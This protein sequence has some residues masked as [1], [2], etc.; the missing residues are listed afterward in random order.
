MDYFNP[1]RNASDRVYGFESH[2]GIF[3]ARSDDGGLSWNHPTTVVSHL[4]DGQ[5][6]VNFEILPEIAVD[7][8][9]S[10]PNGQP[11]PHYGNVYV[12]WS[13][14]YVPGL[15]PGHPGYDGGI[16][17]MLAV[18]RDGG[19]TWE[20]QFIEM[21]DD[22]GQPFLA[23]VI[24]DSL[25]T[26][27]QPG[28]SVIDQKTVD[29]GPAGEIYF[30]GPSCG[31]FGVLLSTDGGATFDPVDHVTGRRIAFGLG[32]PTG[33]VLDPLPGYRFRKFH[34]LMVAA[35]PIR[36]GRA[37]V[38]TSD[39]IFDSRGKPVGPDVIFARSDDY[40]V[41]WREYT[42]AEE[43]AVLNDDNDGRRPTGIAVDVISHQV[44]P[45]LAIDGTGNVGV[46][47]VD[48]RRDTG[49][50]MLDVFGT[51]S[52]DGGQTFSPNFRLTDVSFDADRGRFINAVGNDEY[53]IG[54]YSG[55]A[56]ANNTA[57]AAWTD[58]RGGN[59]DIF[60]A[61]YAIDPAPVAFNDRFEPNDTAGVPTHLG[62]V[63][64]RFLPKLDVPPGDEDWFLM[65]AAAAG[66]VV[67]SVGFEFQDAAIKNASELPD[68]GALVLE[69]RDKTRGTLLATGR[70]VLGLVRVEVESGS[71]ID[72]LRVV[73]K[74][75]RL[76]SDSGHEYLVRVVGVGSET[77]R[78]SLGLQSLTEDLGTRASGSVTGSITD[79]G[80]RCRYW[81]RQQG[82]CSRYHY[83]GPRRC[84]R[85]IWQTACDFSQRYFEYSS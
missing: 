72:Q 52:T 30:A 67:A 24:Q 58:T 53:Y 38:A 44:M 34:A 70:D 68:P 45:R 33:T 3:V 84:S 65:Q 46:V 85:D 1:A 2:N 69:L 14:I 36:P 63:V 10:L 49:N 61:R 4:F 15:F 28:L 42:L 11:N 59:Q 54:D 57:Y 56:M 62:S 81:R 21:I 9:P 51:I 17:N 47:W 82:W 22:D 23:T 25:N 73:G 6:K 12:A 48:T 50:H 55:L 7:N 19:Q 66:E 20:T 74:E 64:Q 16:D 83:R 5:Q 8:F 32:C 79:G 26:F 31:D 13:R 41:S 75:L 27:G 39:D 29:I 43:P 80:G 60:F 71:F 37:Y 35:D 78:Y 76:P 77:V 18:S 40:G